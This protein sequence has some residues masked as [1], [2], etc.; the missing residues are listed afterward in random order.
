M[1]PLITIQ[2]LGVVFTVKERKYKKAAAL[3]SPI[4]EE[5]IELEFDLEDDIEE[6]SAPAEEPPEES[7]EEGKEGDSHE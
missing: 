4:S 7:A 2:V 5:E 1:T 3:T 6:T